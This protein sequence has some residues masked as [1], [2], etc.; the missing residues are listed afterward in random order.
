MRDRQAGQ[1][2][3]VPRSSTRV[4]LIPAATALSASTVIR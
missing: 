3:E 1:V 2:E 4:K